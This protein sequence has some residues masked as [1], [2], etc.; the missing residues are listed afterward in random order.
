MITLRD[1]GS[2]SKILRALMSH[3]KDHKEMLHVL[4]E[5]SPQVL[6]QLHPQH[7]V[8]FLSRIIH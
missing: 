8:F 7:P 3:L 5:N 2:V 6:L 4:V 1:L